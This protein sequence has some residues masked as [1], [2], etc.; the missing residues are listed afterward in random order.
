MQGSDLIY[1]VMPVVILLALVVL[2]ALP[3]AGTRGSGDRLSGRRHSHGHQSRGQ[4]P[5]HSV[6]PDDAGSDAIG[7]G[8]A[9]HRVTAHGHVPVADVVV[10]GG[11]AGD[12]EDTHRVTTQPTDG[13]RSVS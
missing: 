2:I 13:N 8:H 12:H 7:L 4:I 5:D 3:F 6:A 9:Q 11:T 1:I 10:S